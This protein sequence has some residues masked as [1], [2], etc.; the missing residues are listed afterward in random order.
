MTLDN[1]QDNDETQIDNWEEALEI[2]GETVRPDANDG[3][4][5]QQQAIARSYTVNRARQRLKLHK[6]TIQR[7]VDNGLLTAFIDPENNLR[8]PAKEI[9]SLLQDE[10]R[11]EM[12]A[13]NELVN[14]RDIADAL[15]IKT[16]AARKKVR[17]AGLDPKKPRW[18]MVRGKWNLPETLRE[19]RNRIIENRDDKKRQQ[20]EQRDAKKRRR[21]EKREE[22]RRRRNELR[23][24]LVASFPAWSE[25]D[26]SQQM[27]MLHIGPPNSGKTHDALNR[28]AEAG[29]GWYLAPLRLLAWEVADRLNQRGV[30]CNLLT[31][32]EF[33]PIEGAQITA[34]T[35]EMFNANQHGEVVIIDEAQMLAD[36]D[37]GWAWTRAMMSSLAPEMHIIAPQTAEGLIKRMAEA[38]NIPIGTVY[39]ERLAP[40]SVANKTWSIKNMPPKTILVAFSRKMVL[41]LKTRLESFGRTVSVVYGSLPP[42]VRRKQADRFANGE[43]EIC[44]ATDAVGMGLN[45]PADNVCF[46]EVEKFDGRDIRTL[47]SSEIQQIGGRAG[48]YGIAEDTGIIGATRKND[49]KTIR[50]LFYQTPPDLTHARVAPTVEDLTLIPGTLAERLAEWSRLQSIPADL[51]K[52]VKTANMAERVELANR[53]TNLQVAKLGLPHAIQL[54]NAPTRKSTRDFWYDCAIAIIDRAPMPLPPPPPEEVLDTE[55]LDYTETCI[56]CADIYLWLAHRREFHECGEHKELVWH[57]RLEWSNRVDEALLSKIRTAYIDDYR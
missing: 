35:I 4:G 8:I 7:A 54:V 24:Q 22:E 13:A 27:M 34:A 9:E 48:R 6:M 18:E 50:S 29:S 51:R 25:L 28:L 41:T 45:L 43:T 3:T 23:A 32:E 19:F 30:P 17:K 56:S 53:L 36:S 38:A 55:D 2:V 16:A 49:L 5:A 15:G 33:I 31:G 10:E 37:R 1:K 42:E 20:R 26:R 46:Y 39:H 44:V 40:I 57:D 47:Y 12:I 21:E 14:M 11:Y 52:T